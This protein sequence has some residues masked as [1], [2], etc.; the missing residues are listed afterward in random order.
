MRAA[1]SSGGV[2]G[3]IRLDPTGGHCTN[4]DFALCDVGPDG[5]DTS[6]IEVTHLS[7]STNMFIGIRLSLKIMLLR[8]R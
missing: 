2:L 1:L 3:D 7:T 8:R 4:P 5:V 6:Q